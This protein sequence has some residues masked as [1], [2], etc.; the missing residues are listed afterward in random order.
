MKTDKQAAMAQDEKPSQGRLNK[1][2]RVVIWAGIVFILLTGLFPPWRYIRSGGASW[3]WE[4]PIGYS[5][6]ITGPSTDPVVMEDVFDPPTE[7]EKWTRLKM[8]ELARSK[9][10]LQRTVSALEMRL[11]SYSRNPSASPEPNPNLDFKAK[12]SYQTEIKKLE[13]EIA[14]VSE[15]LP[16]ANPNE[17]SVK[18]DVGRFLVQL[19]TIILVT[20]GLVWVMKD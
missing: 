8:A 15:A 7:N 19:L 6:I 5:F 11:L 13:D 4:R 12:E 18:L 16:P 20:M 1:K 10:Q 9:D 17:F 14:K 2:Q 3:S